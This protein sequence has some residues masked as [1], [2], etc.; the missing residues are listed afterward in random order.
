MAVVLFIHH[1][2]PPG[3]LACNRSLFTPSAGAVVR[4]A[5]AFP[6]A[7]P[8]PSLPTSPPHSGRTNTTTGMQLSADNN[9]HGS[10]TPLFSR[11]RYPLEM[12]R[13]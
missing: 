10:T 8:A 11:R 4:P 9:V 6:A 1:Q 3:H 5:P 12:Q 13:Q 2:H 7:L